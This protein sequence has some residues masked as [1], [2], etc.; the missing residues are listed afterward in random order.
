MCVLE[1][2]ETRKLQKRR[3]TGTRASA[4]LHPSFSPPPLLSIHD[5]YHHRQWESRKDALALEY[6]ET[7][8]R[9]RLNRY[10]FGIYV[11]G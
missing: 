11:G 4:M 10:N 6:V 1:A 8:Y 2:K 9:L 3:E 7:V 5:T